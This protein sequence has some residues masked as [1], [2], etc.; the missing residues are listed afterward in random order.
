M[1]RKGDTVLLAGNGR[2]VDD[3]VSELRVSSLLTWAV[4]ISL[5]STQ[6]IKVNL[7]CNTQV[8]FLKIS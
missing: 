6:E 2:L 8:F 1:F 5:G 3:A 4:S 7:V